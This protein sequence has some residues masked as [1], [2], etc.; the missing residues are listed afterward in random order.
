VHAI[1]E[2]VQET[3]SDKETGAERSEFKLNLEAVY[4][5]L[6][7]IEELRFKPKREAPPAVDA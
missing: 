6:I 3:W 1:G 5:S 7:K 4:P 2:L